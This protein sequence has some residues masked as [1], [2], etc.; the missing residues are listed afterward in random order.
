VD[1]VIALA[2]NVAISGDTV[3]RFAVRIR[4]G[5]VL[6]DLRLDYRRRKFVF[7][8]DKGI[9]INYSP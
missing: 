5:L 1:L 8:R 6:N 2:A 9:L 3:I 4:G 7:G